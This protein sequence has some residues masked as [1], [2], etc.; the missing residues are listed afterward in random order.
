MATTGV[1]CRRG[2]ARGHDEASSVRA[3]VRGDAGGVVGC[4]VEVMSDD[5]VNRKLAALEADMRLV[6]VRLDRL[7]AVQGTGLSVAQALTSLDRYDAQEERDQALIR[8]LDELE[9]SI[10]L[11][12]QLNERA[13]SIKRRV[14]DEMESLA[15]ETPDIGLHAYKPFGGLHDD[16]SCEDCGA[17]PGDIHWPHCKA[18]AEGHEGDFL[19]DTI[20][21]VPPDE[22]PNVNADKYWAGGAPP[23]RKRTWRTLWM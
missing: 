8:R 17:A 21:N 6:M 12:G 18:L 3:C 7:E 10:K 23:R 22:T 14:R 2:S 9:R 1:L 5:A 20:T 19:S 15:A 16:G 11:Q 4:G 13:S